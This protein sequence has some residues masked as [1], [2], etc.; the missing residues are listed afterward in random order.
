MVSELFLSGTGIRAIWGIRST[1]GRHSVNGLV[2][3]WLYLEMAGQFGIQTLQSKMFECFEVL[4]TRFFLSL[5]PFD[6]AIELDPVRW[7]KL[8]CPMSPYHM[9]HVVVD[10]SQWQKVFH[11]IWLLLLVPSN[12][13]DRP[14]QAYLNSLHD[15]YRFFSWVEIVSLLGHTFSSVSTRPLA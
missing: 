9:V 8:M 6:D 14:L 7:L 12:E 10:C 13:T 4:R 1:V 3:G 15:L 5:A 11:Q 2:S